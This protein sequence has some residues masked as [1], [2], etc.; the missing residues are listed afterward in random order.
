MANRFKGE[1]TAKSDNTTYTLRCDFN[2]MC[3]FE[4]E[5]GRSALDAIEGFENGNVSVSDMRVMM[6]AFMQHHHPDTTLADAGDL[7]SE[8]VDA[9]QD[10]IRAA[11][12]TA[13]E[14]GDLG[15]GKAKTKVKAA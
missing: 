6:W 5:T 4:G 12:P 1:A 7:L 3:A 10:V 13:D 8:N 15:N 9:L 2:A 14:V 11:S